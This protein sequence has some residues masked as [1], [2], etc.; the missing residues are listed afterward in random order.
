MSKICIVSMRN[1]F[2][3]PVLEKYREIIKEDY[4]IVYW[5]RFGIEEECGAKNYFVFYGPLKPGAGIVAKVYQYF[6]FYRYLRNFL[7]KSSYEKL[8][9][10]PNMTAW[11]MLKYLKHKYKGK[12]I[13]DIRD[14]NENDRQPYKYMTDTAVNNSGLTT[15]VCQPLADY[16]PK[17]REYPINYNLQ[18][19]DSALIEQ[20]RNRVRQDGPIEMSFIGTV[21]FIPEQEKLI[22]L[23]GKDDRFHLNFIG[24][25]SEQL[26]K[27]CTENGYDNVRLVGEFPRSDLGKYY[28]QTD[29]ALNVYGNN[30]I[31]LKVGLSNKVMSSA[32]MGMP[33]LCNTDTY[34]ADVTKEY[35]FGFAIDPDDPSSADKLYE[36]YTSLDIKQLQKNC[37]NFL[38]MIYQGEKEYREIVSNFLNSES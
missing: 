7:K 16:L 23:F 36:Y 38:E 25:G 11:F 28:E 14:H 33:L 30:R 3:S 15:I 37:D 1:I 20:Y 29:I 5:D 21:R 9:V 6:R 31:A 8:I 24:R 17:G 13:L 12:Y 4:D 22:K 27:F 26:E 34:N 35:G 2:S 19:I 18:P 10:S 32:M